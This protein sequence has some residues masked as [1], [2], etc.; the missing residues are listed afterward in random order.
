MKN[1]LLCRW[2]NA[3]N[4]NKKYTWL[5][6]KEYIFSYIIHLQTIKPTSTVGQLTL[7]TH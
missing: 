5:Y 6:N 2:N 3:P 1:F 7:N 4:N